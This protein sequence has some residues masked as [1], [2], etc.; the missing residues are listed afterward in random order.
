MIKITKFVGLDVHKSTIAIAFCEGGPMTEAVQAGTI[1]NDIP[2]VI[3]KLESL[4]DREDL[5]VCYEA[6][7]T[8]YA[9][10]RA[11]LAA[12]IHCIVVA[13]GKVPKEPGK[14]VKTD[15]RDA[16]DLARLLRSGYLSG[17]T[18]PDQARE[19]LRDLVRAREDLMRDLRR[20]RQRLKSMLLRH[21]RKWSGKSCWTLKYR[22]WVRSQRF[23]A[24]ADNIVLKHYL[25]EV[26]HLEAVRD[27]LTDDVERLVPTLNEENLFR[28]LQAL[29]GVSTIVSSTVVCEVG[30]LKRFPTAGRFMSFTGLVPSE[31]SSGN[32]RNRGAITKAGNGHVRSVLIEA[33]WACRST[34]NR[35]LQLLKRQKGLDPKIVDIAWRAQQR[36]HKRYVHMRRKGIEQNV[37]IVALARELAGFI[38]AIG[39]E[40]ETKSVA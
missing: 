5:R 14:R 3:R 23:G 27:L 6:G 39:Q 33:A 25:Q 31:H 13:P 12:G 32:S 40:V 30:D 1:S 10:C 28:S 19:A 16:R 34:P 17:I 2:R 7:P 38:W 37:V 22:E 4:G 21:D 15:E 24:E 9:L 29:R 20:A 18:L 11:L 26:E 36:L 8:G 35:S